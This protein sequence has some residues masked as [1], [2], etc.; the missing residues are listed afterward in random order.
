MATGSWVK[1]PLWLLI[2]FLLFP[3]QFSAA[4]APPDN[5]NRVKSYT[6]V[7]GSTI[8]YRYYDSGTSRR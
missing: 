1:F 2:L 5:L 4:A 8:G 3:A 6:D 7:N